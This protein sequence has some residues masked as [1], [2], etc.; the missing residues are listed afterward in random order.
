MHLVR[1]FDSPPRYLTTKQMEV[2]R[3][4]SDASFYTGGEIEESQLVLAGY[5]RLEMLFAGTDVIGSWITPGQRK[6]MWKI[7][8]PCSF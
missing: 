8:A 3:L 4:L 7:K 5:D 6:G 2:I 1:W